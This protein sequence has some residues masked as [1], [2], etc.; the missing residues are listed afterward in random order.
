M[1][2]GQGVL[3]CNMFCYCLNNPVNMADESGC[4][5]MPAMMDDC[6]PININYNKCQINGRIH[7]VSIMIAQMKYISFS[8]NNMAIDTDGEELRGEDGCYQNETAYHFPNGESMN[9]FT[10]PYVVIPKNMMENIGKGDFAVLT[11]NN[12]GKRVYAIVGDVSA[13]GK[14]VHEVSVFASRKLGYT[15]AS[16]KNGPTGNFTIRIYPGTRRNWSSNNFYEQITTYG[17]N[18]YACGRIK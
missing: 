4:V 18:L 9:A 16:G 15:N 5:A 2:T 3:G 12:T 13:A 11:D 6:Y 8:F 10:M 1:S 7:N 17:R 14:D